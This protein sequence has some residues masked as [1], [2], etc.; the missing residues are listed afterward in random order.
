MG[1][2]AV[3]AK[4]NNEI[5]RSWT[6][7]RVAPS[8]ESTVRSQYFS[9]FWKLWKIM[10]LNCSTFISLFPI[11]DRGLDFI[12]IISISLLRDHVATDE[13]MENECRTNDGLEKQ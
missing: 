4:S 5:R 8:A 13:R 7:Y 12:F 9:R 2:I 6:S 11:G 10:R 3:N 1:E